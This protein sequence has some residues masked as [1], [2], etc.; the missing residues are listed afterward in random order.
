MR[1][2]AA[3]SQ[4]GPSARAGAQDGIDWVDLEVISSNLAARRLY[5]RSG[6]VFAGELPDLFRID[7]ERLGYVFMTHKT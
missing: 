3:P 2:S 1:H 4:A 5:E 6:F 7:G